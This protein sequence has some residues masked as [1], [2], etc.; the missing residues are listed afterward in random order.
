M[1]PGNKDLCLFPLNLYQ[2]FKCPSILTFSNCVL[3]IWLSTL[4]ILLKIWKNISFIHDYRDFV[5]DGANIH[6]NPVFLDWLDVTFEG[7]VF[8]MGATTHGRRG[9][10][11]QPV[12][13][14]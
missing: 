12:A 14:T 1:M 11:G 6:R 8:A 7:R 9:R 4:P 10:D 2:L 3:F 13:L 5:Q